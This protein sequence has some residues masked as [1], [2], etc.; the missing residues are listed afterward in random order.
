MTEGLVSVQSDSI[1]LAA[2]EDASS[3]CLAHHS[4]VEDL[5]HGKSEAGAEGAAAV[6]GLRSG[7]LATI[8]ACVN[9]Q[10]SVA[11]FRDDK[12]AIDDFLEP[13]VAARVLSSNEARLGLASPKLSMLCKIGEYA[14]RLRQKALVDYLLETGCSGHTLIYQLTVLLDQAPDNLGGEERAQQ[15]VDTLRQKHIETRQ[16]MLGLTKELKRAKLETVSIAPLSL[17][18]VV[19]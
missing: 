7:V 12:T 16:G 3:H 1:A 15:L 17:D 14:D 13:F 6:A 9:I 4:P 8:D 2:N 5:Y 10:E 19:D 11:K 18:H